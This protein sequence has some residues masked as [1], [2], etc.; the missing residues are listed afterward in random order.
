MRNDIISPP[1]EDYESLSV[2]IWLGVGSLAEE[3]TS[4][5]D[6][7]LPLKEATDLL[8]PT[9]LACQGYQV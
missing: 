2:L 1:P 3:G 7:D 4:T 6:P 9:P 5:R 8:E